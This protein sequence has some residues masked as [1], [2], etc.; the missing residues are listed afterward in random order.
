MKKSFGFPCKVDGCVEWTDQ[1]DGTIFL[2]CNQHLLEKHN[3]D[4]SNRLKVASE[5]YFEPCDPDI[6]VR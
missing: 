5:S 3:I 2:L 4:E 1:L 6:I